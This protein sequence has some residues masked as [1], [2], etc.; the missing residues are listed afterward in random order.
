MRIRSGRLR[1]V[2]WSAFALFATN[3]HSH[4]DQHSKDPGP[5]LKEQKAWGIAADPALAQR[6]LR[7]SMSDR[8][9]FEPDSLVV[10]QGE[11]VR[12]LVTN[13]G[14]LKHELVIGTKPVLEEHAALMKK[15]PNMEH[16]EP[17][18]VHVAPGK[19]GEIVWT[20]NRAGEFHFACL[21]AGHYEAGMTGKILVTGRDAAAAAG[22]KK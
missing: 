5:V 19:T 7:I 20:F 12:L 1:A 8:M 21:I 22:Q 15:F 11:T 18:M 9:R 3:V 17:Y 16:D 10:K 6:T 14:K 4:G 13:D 2:A